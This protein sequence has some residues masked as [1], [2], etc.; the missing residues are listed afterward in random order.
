M[1]PGL[2]NFLFSF[3]SN[4]LNRGQTVSDFATPHTVEIT[5]KDKNEATKGEVHILTDRRMEDREL[6]KHLQMLRLE[7]VL[8]VQEKERT[9]KSFECVT[10]L[11]ISA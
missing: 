8:E 4:K 7:S 11:N 1:F 6:R 5:S 9:D 10:S 3:F 2:A